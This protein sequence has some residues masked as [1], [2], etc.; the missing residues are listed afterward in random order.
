MPLGIP[1]CNEDMWYISIL[2]LLS[3]IPYTSCFK[4]ACESHLDSSA[5]K[6]K[7][8]ATKYEKE[9]CRDNVLS[10]I[11]GDLYGQK[12]WAAK[13][14]DLQLIPIQEE[15]LNTTLFYPGF[16]VVVQPP[17]T[18]IQNVRGFHLFYEDLDTNLRKCI[19]IVIDNATLD[20]THRENDLKFKIKLWP[21]NGDKDFLITSWTLPKPPE[22]ELD[23]NLIR[24]GRTG[25]WKWG[26]T[27]ASSDWIT[28]ISYFNNIDDMYIRIWFVAAPVEYKFSQYIVSLEQIKS[29]EETDFED[30]N[31]TEESRVSKVDYTFLNVKPGRYRI[32]VQPFDDNCTC[33]SKRNYCGQC[34]RTRTSVIIVPTT[35][36]M[37]LTRRIERLQQTSP[38]PIRAVLSPDI[39]KTPNQHILPSVL[40][41]ITFLL[42]IIV[43]VGCYKFY[44]GN[45]NSNN[46][47]NI[48]N[49][50]IKGKN[51]ALNKRSRIVAVVAADDGDRHNTL[52]KSFVIF[53][54]ESCKLNVFFF[55]WSQIKNKN[56]WIDNTVNKSDHIVFI[57]SKCS[58]NQYSQWI[59][60]AYRQ[61]CDSVFM[62]CIETV[63]NSS[64]GNSDI[65]K[66]TILVQFGHSKNMQVPFD[67]CNKHQ[68][69]LVKQFY[70]FF[71]HI[72]DFHPWEDD[73]NH[74]CNQPDIDI[75][76]SKEG[77]DFM[78]A[79]NEAMEYNPDTA[80]TTKESWLKSIYP[81]IEC[82]DALHFWTGFNEAAEC[83]L[84]TVSDSELAPS[85]PCIDFIPPSI[86]DESYD[87]DSIDQQAAIKHL[88]EK[89]SAY[90]DSDIFD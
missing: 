16:L 4:L 61:H 77:R 89:N 80:L 30:R 70:E 9:N 26:L 47:V 12:Y 51:K 63:L 13:P 71:C 29:G 25:K 40:G 42:A 67:L 73:F 56:L 76:T 62:K 36:D 86:Q 41:F 10:T 58:V 28:T 82:I 1:S 78:K 43:I 19:I 75:L 52:V 38:D 45:R 14:H 85:E 18:G 11:Y 65:S 69:L 84:R 64:I 23:T 7:C 21:L 2:F 31:V 22:S 5:F 83:N 20:H 32:L 35:G 49:T 17:R 68:Y 66:K 8:T 60:S 81:E 3:C 72:S 88:N 55:P 39:S 44:K 37:P 27:N 90:C 34:I 79:F 57:L 33:K 48:N 6:V 59:E 54:R 24:N 53:L 74:F 50:D 87:I 46:D 15:Y